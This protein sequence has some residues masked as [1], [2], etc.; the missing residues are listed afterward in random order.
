MSARSIATPW[1]VPSPSAAA[2]PLQQIEVAIACDRVTAH[3]CRALRRLRDVPK[4]RE[5]RQW[6]HR[7]EDARD[8]FSGQK[9]A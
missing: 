1:S 4:R 6:L 2:N 8:G 9:A 5:V 3:N 7:A